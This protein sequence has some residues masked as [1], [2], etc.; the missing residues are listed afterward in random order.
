MHY[1]FPCKNVLFDVGIIEME[2]SR[3]VDIFRAEIFQ[4]SCVFYEIPTQFK[5]LHAWLILSDSY[6]EERV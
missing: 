2:L 1:A 5:F 6:L 3:G 4:P